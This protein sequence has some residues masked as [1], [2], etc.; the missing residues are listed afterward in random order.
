MPG[1]STAACAKTGVAIANDRIIAA[2][3]SLKLV[4]VDSLRVSAPVRVMRGPLTEKSRMCLLIF[5]GARNREVAVKPSSSLRKHLMP[6]APLVHARVR[7]SVCSSSQTSGGLCANIL[8]PQIIYISG[9]ELGP[10]AGLVCE[11]RLVRVSAASLE[12]VRISSDSLRLEWSR[13]A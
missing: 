2:L 9:W 13:R 7:Y 6:S 8:L 1:S 4:I 3:K 12:I 5:L 11:G 10:R